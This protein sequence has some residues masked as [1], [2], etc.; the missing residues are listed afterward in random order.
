MAGTPSQNPAIQQL[1]NRLAGMEP[2][3]PDA[4][5]STARTLRDWG[6]SPMLLEKPDG[7]LEMT[8]DQAL[9]AFDHIA[10]QPDEYWKD[11]GPS[12][13]AEETKETALRMLVN[14]FE[15]F[16]RLRHN[17]PEAWDDMNELYMED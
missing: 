13:D 12:D 17:E 15:F 2:S 10:A 8:R 16:T 3:D 4:I 6:Y 14:Q 11:K 5:E 7:F 9:E 1:R